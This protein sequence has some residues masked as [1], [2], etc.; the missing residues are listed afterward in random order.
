MS[1]PRAVLWIDHR[2]AQLLQLDG[3]GSPA[4]R[5]HAHSHYTRQHGSRVRSEHEFFAHVCD[6]LA[7][8]AQVLVTGSRQVQADFGRYVEKH[9]PG[10]GPRIV[11]WETVDHPTQGQLL[12]LASEFFVKYDLFASGP[13]TGVK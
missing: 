8:D 6:A 12:A 9:R 5:I 7:A 1:S 3:A 13:T 11:G 2:S 10:T 4:Q